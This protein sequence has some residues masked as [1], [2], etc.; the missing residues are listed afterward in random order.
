MVLEVEAMSEGAGRDIN[1]QAESTLDKMARGMTEETGAQ[2][3]IQAGIQGDAQERRTPTHRGQNERDGAGYDRGDGWS[4]GHTPTC[5]AQ[6]ERDGTEDV[7]GGLKAPVRGVPAVD[8]NEK[9]P[10]ITLQFYCN[11]AATGLGQ[12]RTEQKNESPENV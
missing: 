2:G 3:D 8:G 11:R 5:P 6:D 1:P 12:S 4:W 9:H 10:L 7:R